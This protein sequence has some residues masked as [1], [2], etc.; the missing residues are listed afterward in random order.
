YF[1]I[2]DPLDFAIQFRKENR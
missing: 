2:D 1:Y